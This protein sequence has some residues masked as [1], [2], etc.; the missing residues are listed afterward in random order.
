MTRASVRFLSHRC[1]LLS[2]LN[3]SLRRCFRRQ[4][5]KAEAHSSIHLSPRSSTFCFKKTP[6]LHQ[7]L[8]PQPQETQKFRGQEQQKYRAL[9][10]DQRQQIVPQDGTLTLSAN[11]CLV[12][13]S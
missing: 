10:E 2:L 4:C 5:Q 9:L 7:D 3:L 11:G 6:L 1:L 12:L 8:H 13:N